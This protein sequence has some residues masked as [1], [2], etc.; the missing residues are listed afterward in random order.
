MALFARRNSV[1]RLQTD[2]DRLG[3][4]AVLLNIKRD[5][6]RSALEDAIAA[7]QVHLLEGDIDDAKAATTLQA[8]VNTAQ[9]ELAGFDIAIAESQVR[10]N[11]AELALTAEA[12]R[13][14]CEADAAALGAVIAGLEKNFEPWLRATRAI[15]AGLEEVNGFRYQAAPLAAFYRHIASEGEFALRVVLDDLSGAIGEVARGERA[16]T[17]GKPETTPVAAAPAGQPRDHFTY[18]VPKPGATYRVP[19]AFAKEK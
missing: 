12:R 14:K 11:T 10:I 15:A 5:A 16:I 9:S 18:T 2:L 13:I 6:A 7:R 19:A 17:I 1:Q 4:R 8:R 3:A